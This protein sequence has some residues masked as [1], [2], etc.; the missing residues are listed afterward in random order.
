M[1][2]VDKKTNI[3]K[4]ILQKTEIDFLL[5]SL[6]IE[7][8]ETRSLFKMHVELYQLRDVTVAKPAVM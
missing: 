2:S 8:C 6:N 7:R 5:L 3:I 4:K 1:L